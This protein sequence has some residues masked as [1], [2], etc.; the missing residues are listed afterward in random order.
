MPQSQATR[1]AIADRI[2]AFKSRLFALMLDDDQLIDGGISS[3]QTIDNDCSAFPPEDID[4][5][6]FVT[7]VVTT[8]SVSQ[9]LVKLKLSPVGDAIDVSLGSEVS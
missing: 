6:T 4:G 2:E 5:E 7:H 9:K 8:V 3:F 1:S